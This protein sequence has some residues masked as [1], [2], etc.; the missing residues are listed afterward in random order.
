MELQAKQVEDIDMT[1]DECL[2]LYTGLFSINVEVQKKAYELR[3]DYNLDAEQA[4]RLTAIEQQL[5]EDYFAI[6]SFND[7]N[8][9][10]KDVLRKIH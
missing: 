3:N 6:A 5:Q 4:S 9:E 10:A 1:K 2:M 8:L 7:R